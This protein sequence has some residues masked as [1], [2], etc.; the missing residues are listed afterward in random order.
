MQEKIVGISGKKD[1]VSENL[2][3]N[4]TL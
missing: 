2:H 4:F 1:S 3:V